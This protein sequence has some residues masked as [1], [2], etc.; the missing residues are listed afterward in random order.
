MMV[1]EPGVRPLCDGG[2]MTLLPGVKGL[3]DGG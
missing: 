1:A 2:C 3:Y